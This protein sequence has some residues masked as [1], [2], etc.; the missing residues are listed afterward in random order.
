MYRTGNHLN[1]APGIPFMLRGGTR[2]RCRGNG[3][4]EGKGWTQS[5]EDDTE[6]RKTMETLVTVKQT[7]EDLENFVTGLAVSDM[8]TFA[9]RNG[10]IFRLE[11]GKW[12]K[13]PSLQKPVV[14]LMAEGNRLYAGGKN[15]V[16][17]SVDKG[18]TWTRLG[19][20]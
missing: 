1:N 20:F 18:E 5:Q 13:V 16:W 17:V 6:V 8:G 14:S 11:D 19:T 4:E 2:S 7:P 9:R 12:R 3:E 10:T 15:A